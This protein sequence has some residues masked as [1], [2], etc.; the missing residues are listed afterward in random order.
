MQDIAKEHGVAIMRR[1]LTRIKEGWIYKP[2][3]MTQIAYER[4][5]I[6]TNNLHLYTK[7]GH[8]DEDRKILDKEFSLHDIIASCTDFAEEKTLLQTNSEQIGKK[9]NMSVLI[10]RTPKCHPELAGEGIEYTWENAK[11]FI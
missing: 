4:G 7:D 11:Q 10:D 3:G 5:L 9:R 2:K 6:D 1:E 8:R